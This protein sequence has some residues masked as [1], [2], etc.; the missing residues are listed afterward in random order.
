MGTARRLSDSV[1]ECGVARDRG[2]T[3][4]GRRGSVWNP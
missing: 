1:G 4:Q 2:I 3:G